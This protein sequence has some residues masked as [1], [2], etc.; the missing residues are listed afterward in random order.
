M[1]FWHKKSNFKVCR[2]LPRA[3]GRGS[4]PRPHHIQGDLE[5]LLKRKRKK[6]TRSWLAKARPHTVETSI[7]RLG[8]GLVAAFGDNSV[9]EMELGCCTGT[10]MYGQN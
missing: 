10:N 5:H 7:T 3:T 1:L 2:E 4:F 9:H 6:D 8:A